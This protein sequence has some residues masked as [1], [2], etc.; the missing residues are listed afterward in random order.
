MRRNCTSVVA[1]RV[2]IDGDFSTLP[3]EAGWAGE[4]IVFVQA[5]GHHPDLRLVAQVSPDGLAWV[6]RGPGVV[7]RAGEHIAELP[8]TVFGN[9][10][11][12]SIT[13]ASAAAPARILVHINAKG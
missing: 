3:F 7:L 10:V 13:G 9:W 6:S 8:L 2:R 4:V 12:V 5:E 11:R 1:R